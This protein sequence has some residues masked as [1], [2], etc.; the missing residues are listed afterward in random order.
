M[1]VDAEINRETLAAKTLKALCLGYAVI[2]N[3]YFALACLAMSWESFYP[4][5]RV[6][7]IA[8]GLKSAAFALMFLVIA[9]GVAFGHR[10]ARW[11]SIAFGALGLGFSVF[12]FWDG[13]L[14]I[15]SKYS[16]EESSEVLAAIVFSITSLL[17][18][19]AMF[20]P[21]AKNYFRRKCI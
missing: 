1:I 14:R 18:I 17:V 20:A 13:Y 12:L 7:Q 16:G 5:Y 8:S 11:V 19:L 3:S 15:K 21:V 9:L 6:P 10:W 4:R 2:F